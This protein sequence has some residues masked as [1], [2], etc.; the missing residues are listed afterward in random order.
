MDTIYVL[1]PVY[2]VEKVLG[3]CIRSIQQQTF[4]NWQLIL[5]DDG[6]TDGSGAICDEFSAKD[7]RI[8]VIH[9]QNAGSAVARINGIKQIDSEGY[10][11]FCDSDDEM[12]KNAL[13]VL[14]E[15]AIRSDADI[16]CG[17]SVR[18]A[19]GIKVTRGSKQGCF[20]N[21]KVYNKEEITTELYLSCFGLSGFPIN[22]CGKLYKT[23]VLREIM[24][25]LDCSPKYFGDD[26]NVT[27]RIMPVV[28]RISVIKDIVYYY[29]MGGG[30]AK[31]MPSFLD[32]CL[33]MYHL[34]LKWSEK[35]TSTLDLKRLIGVEL[36]N[37]AVSYWVMCEKCKKYPNGN[38]M[39]EVKAVCECV[40]VQ[41]AIAMLEG[42][43]SGIPG[44]NQM[45]IEHNYAAICKLVCQKVKKDKPKDT[46][47]KI[48]LS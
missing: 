48:L 1:I 47:K 37:I 8:T 6:S 42:D 20:T 44:M 2:N 10:C 40:E 14:Y 36:K 39:A 7:S 12:P 19:K 23:E 15:E 45:L 17:N 24:L 32:D 41:E 11:V 31:F 4:Q 33:M 25:N 35:C 3:K 27:M 28:N 16:V 5:V 46:I 34:K 43:R 13:Q 22:M 29:R 21:P 18:I 9:T 26:L 38:L 30:T